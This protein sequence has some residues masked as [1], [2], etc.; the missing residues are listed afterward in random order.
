MAMAHNVCARIWKRAYSSRGRGK[1]YET[2]VW[3]SVCLDTL[4]IV[5][6]YRFGWIMVTWLCFGF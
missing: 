5:V 6:Q 2:W 1:K 4:R 3:Y